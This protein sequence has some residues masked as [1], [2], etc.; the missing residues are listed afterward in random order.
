ML[1]DFG[2]WEECDIDFV[3]S[4]KLSVFG[5]VVELL[6]GDVMVELGKRMEVGE[7]FGFCYCLVGGWN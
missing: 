1:D 6:D 5:E 4:D 2:W 7:V 3:K